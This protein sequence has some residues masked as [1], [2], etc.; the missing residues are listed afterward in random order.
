MLEQSSPLLKNQTLC[1][2]FAMLIGELQSK[3]I[4]DF[5]NYLIFSECGMVP[6]L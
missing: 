3:L 4:L 6:F 1:P 2:L 5:T